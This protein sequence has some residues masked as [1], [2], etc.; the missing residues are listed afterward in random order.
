MDIA[1]L[2]RCKALQLEMRVFWHFK[3]LSQEELIVSL[4][5]LLSHRLR[6]RHQTRK[7]T[8]LHIIEPLQVG[9]GAVVSSTTNPPFRT[10]IS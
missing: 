9:Y 7:K 3:I 5:A 6:E 4:E 10:T 2:R 1:E 8:R